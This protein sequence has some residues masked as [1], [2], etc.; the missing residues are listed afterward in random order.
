MTTV[1]RDIDT[2]INDIL[3]IPLYQVGNPLTDDMLTPTNS[4]LF[5]SLSRTSMSNG[6]NATVG[7]GENIQ[8]A[9]DT[10][11]KSGGGTVYILPGTY[12]LQ[13]DINV[14]SGVFLEG[15]NRDNTIIDCNLSYKINMSGEVTYLTGTVSITNGTTTVTGSGTAWTSDLVGNEIFL[16]GYYYP[17]ASVTSTTQLELTYSYDGT[18]LSGADYLIA[19][20][21]RNPKLRNLTV[22]NATGTAI[23]IH[24]VFEP[25]IDDLQV[26]GSGIG[27]D[28]SYVVFPRYLSANYENGI[29]TSMSHVAGFK[30]DWS[31]FD[32]SFVGAGLVLDNCQDSTIFDSG[33]VHNLTNG[34]EFTDCKNVKI[35]SSSM[36]NNGTNGVHFISGNSDIQFIAVSIKENLSDGIRLTDSTD[37]TS[38]STSS[39][40]DNGGYGINILSSTCDNNNITTISFNNNTLGNLNDNGTNTNYVGA[41][42]FGFNPIYTVATLPELRGSEGFNVPS[43]YE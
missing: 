7:N 16:D 17:I 14:P 21:V 13:K 36:S 8:V 10:M 12:V 38:M 1:T 5:G 35:L 15:V 31:S 41:E 2:N 9:I 23:Q 19:S 28:F 24:Y 20:L 33:I 32:Y 22:H 37:R 26:Y 42:T 43:D 11:F 39:I 30:I 25:I 29:N 27:I 18:T 6:K 4:L 40:I 3:P 34:I